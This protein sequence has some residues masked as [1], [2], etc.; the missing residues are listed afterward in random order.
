[1]GSKEYSGHHASID[2]QGG[3]RGANPKREPKKMREVK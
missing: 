2:G 1:M 3:Q